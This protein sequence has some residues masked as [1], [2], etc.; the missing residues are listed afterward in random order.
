MK[1]LS[2]GRIAAVVTAATLATVSIALIILNI[3]IPVK[4]LSSYFVSGS[5]A[6]SGVMRVSF[7]DVGYGDCTIIELP[8]G[9]NMLMDAG[10]GSRAHTAK[11]L[12]TL[13]E[14]K[15]KKIDFLLC[16]S[17]NAEHCGGLFEI[18]KYKKVD[19]VYLPCCDKNITEQFEK[20]SL[21]AENC[22]RAVI[23]YGAGESG[24]GWYFKALSPSVV[25]NPYG[26]YAELEKNPL[27]QSAR[28]NA[29]AVIWLEYAGTSFL[30]AGDVEKT[31][32][33]GMCK[34]YSVI[35]SDY[36]VKLETC[37]IFKAA[38]HGSEKSFCAPFNELIK[39][40]ITIISTDGRLTADYGN[41]KRTDNGTV[42]IE[43]TADGYKEIT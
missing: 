38:G 2:K 26:E 22:E 13:N 32:L 10:D 17:V 30:F 36:P 39:S 16:T 5:R 25:S 33:D 37:N 11:I 3:F 19:K 14:R 6:E 23:E 8:D 34:T 29:S 41:A 1:K 27:S 9:K 18:L 7:L 31:V 40:E 43:V 4:Y 42:V 35:G 20:F 12:K 24:D 15:I 21:A 28:N